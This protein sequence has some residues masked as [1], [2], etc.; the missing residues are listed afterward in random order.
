MAK[1]KAP[2]SIRLD[3]ETDERLEL[4]AEELGLTKHGLA[5]MAV[6]A[7]VRAIAENNY[8]LVLPIR[9]DVSHVPAP[10][11]PSGYPPHRETSVIIEE[12]DQPKKSKGKK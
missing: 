7:A 9:F 6:K 12:R 2:L 5:Q 8:K 3:P 1:Q 4:V 10:R 11:D